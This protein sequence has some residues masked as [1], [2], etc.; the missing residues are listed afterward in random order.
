MSAGYTRGRGPGGSGRGARLLGL[1]GRRHHPVR[2]GHHASSI[3]ADAADRAAA[4]WPTG[5]V[6]LEAPLDDAWIRDIGP[7]VRRSDRRRARRPAIDW[8]FNGW[9]AQA[10]ATW[11]K[12]AA[13]AGASSPRLPAC[14]RSPRDGQRGWRHPRRRR[15]T[16]AD[17]RDRPARQGRNPDWTPG[18]GRGGAPRAPSARTASIW[19]RARADPRLRRLFGTRGHVDIVA[20]FSDESTVLF[21]DQLDPAHPDH[22]CQQRGAGAPRSGAGPARRRRARPG[23]IAR[24]RGLGRLL[25]HQPL[26]LQRRGD[27]VRVRRSGGRARPRRSCA[28]RTPAARSCSSTPGHCSLAEAASTASRSSSRAA[29]PRERRVRPD[30]TGHLAAAR[31]AGG[32][33]R[34][35][36]AHPAAG[37]GLRGH[38]PGGRGHDLRGPASHRRRAGL[39][40]RLR[41]RVDHARGALGPGRRRTDGRRQSGAHLPGDQL[42]RHRRVLPRP[43][44]RARR[45]CRRRDP[46]LGALSAASE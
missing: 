30:P 37:R 8:V 11:D 38:Y 14:R 12:D 13:I 33:V 24:R 7:D 43:P 17:H 9:G 28:T 5:R 41:R 10:W 27:P 25:V 4:G 44:A 16:G 6:I 15:G 29:A 40:L 3:P 22:A 35:R 31:R 21:H 19:L 34:L 46:R 26:R 1:R 39:G 18:A 32:R 2:A 45:S 42:Q 23:H 36:L 20:C